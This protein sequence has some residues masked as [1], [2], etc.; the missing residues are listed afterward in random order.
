MSIF[1]GKEH[2]TVER[3]YNNLSMLI[4]KD[5]FGVSSL[6]RICPDLIITTQYSN[7][8][9]FNFAF[10]ASHYGTNIKRFLFY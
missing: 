7:V 2:F 3:E 6:N 4:I 5:D 8:I 9:F 10:N 1:R